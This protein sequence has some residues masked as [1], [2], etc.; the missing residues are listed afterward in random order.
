M[1]TTGDFVADP[2][3]VGQL[4][5]ECVRAADRMNQGVNGDVL[6]LHLQPQTVG[7]LPAGRRVYES[8]VRAKRATEVVF[9]QLAQAHDVNA[10]RLFDVADRYATTNAEGDSLFQSLIKYIGI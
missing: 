5:S 7:D 1:Q 6:M 3:L 2:A 4:A 10:T 8:H 9:R